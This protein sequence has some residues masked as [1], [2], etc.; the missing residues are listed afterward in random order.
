MTFVRNIIDQLF[1]GSSKKKL[2]SE[3]QLMREEYDCEFN[4]LGTEE[5]FYTSHDILIEELSKVGRATEDIEDADFNLSRYEGDMSSIDVVC[6]R[7]SAK[8]ILAVRSAQKQFSEPY[9]VCL[10]YEEVEFTILSDGRV[11]GSSYDDEDIGI[12]KRFGFEV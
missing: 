5:D 8:V 12:L 3:C 9:P 2:R 6:N 10:D 4:I 7:Y 1:D 11:F